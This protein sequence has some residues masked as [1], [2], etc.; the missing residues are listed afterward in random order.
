L[1]I[2]TALFER[3]MWRYRDPRSWRAV[4]ADVGHA[5]ALF[6][7]VSRRLGWGHHT[8][9]TFCDS[10]ISRLLRLEPLRQAPLLV[11]TLE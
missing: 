4:L 11:A 2:F 5:V 6:R 10:A 9:Q 7:V 8:C 1:V 3:S